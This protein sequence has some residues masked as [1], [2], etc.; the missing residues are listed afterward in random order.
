MTDEYIKM[1][2][3]LDKSFFERWEWQA[4]DTVI[5]GST[6]YYVIGGNEK[7]ALLINEKMEL[8]STHNLNF[9]PLVTN[10]RPI[11]GHKQLL[12]IYKTNKDLQYDSL[13]L[14]WLANWIEDKVT[15]DHGFCFK[16]ESAE[17]IALLWVQETCFNKMWDGT[18]WIKNT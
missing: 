10:C 12:H 13:A 11:P 15:E 17:A 9:G 1:I 2:L 18:K 8:S 16:Y 5:S 14:L 4:G 6:I 3:A 7:G